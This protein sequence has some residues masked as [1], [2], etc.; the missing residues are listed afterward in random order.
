MQST[1]SWPESFWFVFMLASMLPD[2]PLSI[3]VLICLIK[4][5]TCRDPRGPLCSR[6]R[7]IFL[8][9]VLPGLPK[10][11]V[12]RPGGCVRAY[13][14]LTRHCAGTSHALWAGPHGTIPF[15]V[16]SPLLGP[17]LLF[18]NRQ[19]SELTQPVQ[20]LPLMMILTWAG[21]QTSLSHLPKDP[22]IMYYLPAG[23]PW[24]LHMP[25]L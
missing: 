10:V 6:H 4:Y 22:W 25:G 15:P 2:R 12:P 18:Y 7:D 14:S 24:Q 1:K 8:Q 23:F 11:Q 17:G 13:S 16:V 19:E 21:L 3:R 5:V 20:F 9:L